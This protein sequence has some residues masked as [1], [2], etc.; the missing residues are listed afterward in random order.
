MRNIM[1][2]MSFIYTD[3]RCISIVIHSTFTYLVELVEN[4]FLHMCYQMIVVHWMSLLLTSDHCSVLL[5]KI[6][7]A[8]FHIHNAEIEVYSQPYFM[9]LTVLLLYVLDVVDIEIEGNVCVWRHMLQCVIHL[10]LH[11]LWLHTHHCSCS[12]FLS[13]WQRSWPIFLTLLNIYVIIIIISRFDI[14]N[15]ICM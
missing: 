10:L 3:V 6:I 13:C 4:Y 14:N 11:H 8:M 7:K 9:K 12:F 5:M 2:K 1:L 15:T